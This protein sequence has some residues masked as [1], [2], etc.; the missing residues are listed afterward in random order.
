MN[1]ELE[2]LDRF[3]TDWLARRATQLLCLALG[4]VFLWFGVLK[5]FSGLSPAE[6]LI[7]KTVGWIV[8]PDW[9]IPVLAAW[10]CAIG[11][12]LLLR[13]RLRFTLFLLG[14]HMAGTFLPLVVCPDDVW[15][16]FPYAW[17]LEGQY[18][19]KNL[20]LIGA[21]LAVAGSLRRPAEV[22]IRNAGGGPFLLTRAASGW[23]SRRLP[24]ESVRTSSGARVRAGAPLIPDYAA[25]RARSAVNTR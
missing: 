9:F 8:D 16:R 14:A 13:R 18:I 20:V 21:G 1:A 5:F 15:T 24:G 11:L 22:G 6:G 3:V 25:L 2:R 19:L 4:I 10:E 7:E 17:T 12:G 23:Q